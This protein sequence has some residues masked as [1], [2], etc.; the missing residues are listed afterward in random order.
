VNVCSNVVVNTQDD[1]PGSLRFALNCNPPGTQILFNIL[2]AADTIEV[3]SPI[4]ITNN[5]QIINTFNDA[6]VIKAAAEGPIFKV[7]SGANVNLEKLKLLSG[8]GNAGRAI[9][10]AGT[11]NL[12][13]IDVIDLAGQNGG[14]TVKNS[15]ALIIEGSTGILE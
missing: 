3:L 2:L 10:N 15:G 5:F 9:D 1:G 6:V 14:S 11:L 13:N 8:Q 12:K 7:N 4:E